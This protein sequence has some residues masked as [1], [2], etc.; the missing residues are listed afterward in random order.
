MTPLAQQF[1]DQLNSMDPDEMV[2]LR[3]K[4]GN[5]RLSSYPVRVVREA[6]VQTSACP[7]CHG[8]SADPTSGS[9]GIG[10]ACRTCNG[11]GHVLKRIHGIIGNQI[12]RLRDQ[13]VSYDPHE[14]INS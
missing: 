4:V 7:E 3:P 1:L 14:T 13:H 12:D 9:N 2:D 11:R 8:Q 5:G 6:M 10:M